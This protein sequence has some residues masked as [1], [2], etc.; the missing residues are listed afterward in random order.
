M[1]RFWQFPENLCIRS[2]AVLE[3]GLDIWEQRLGIWIRQ[4]EPSNMGL[5]AAMPKPVLPDIGS[6]HIAAI[7]SR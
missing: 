4:H 3:Q 2:E 7:K 5:A 1:M 6:K